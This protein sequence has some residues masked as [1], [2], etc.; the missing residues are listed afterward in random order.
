MEFVSLLSRSVVGRRRR[1]RIAGQI[2]NNHRVNDRISWLT[3]TWFRRRKNH[4]FRRTYCGRLDHFVIACS[5]G[6]LNTWGSE[7]W[8]TDSWCFRA[9]SF[10]SRVAAGRIC[11]GVSKIQADRFVDIDS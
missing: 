11:D 6:D 7:G 2:R 5:F 10:D 1:E 8:L 9:F 4:R 3:D